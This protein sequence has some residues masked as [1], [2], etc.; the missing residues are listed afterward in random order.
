MSAAGEPIVAGFVHGTAVVW[1]NI[2]TAALL[3]GPSGSGKS[4]LAFR[5]I[6]RGW[7]LVADDQ[8]LLSAKDDA[9]FATA[10]EELTGKLALPGLGILSVPC[11]QSAALTHIVHL[12]ATAPRFPLDRQRQ[13]VCGLLRPIIFIDGLAASAPMRVEA[14]VKGAQI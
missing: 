9:I 3:L 11:V 10:A 8:V 13:T 4:D 5:L 14:F 2:G 6:D 7:Q 1:P 12:Q